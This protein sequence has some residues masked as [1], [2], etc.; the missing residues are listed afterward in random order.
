MNSIQTIFNRPWDILY[1]LPYSNN[2]QLT[3]RQQKRN[4]L[5]LIQGITKISINALKSFID[6]NIIDFD[7]QVGENLCQIRAYK[8]IHLADFWLNNLDNKNKLI[9]SI[10][11]LNEY[12]IN[13][14]LVIQEWEKSISEL[15]QYDKNLDGH[16]TIEEFLKRHNIYIKL[17]E[18][19]IYL[20]SCYFLTHY[21]ILD[22]NIPVAINFKE[23]SYAL[24]VSK[25]RAERLTHRYQLIVAKLGCDFIIKI[26][27]ELPLSA[28]Y[29]KL[30]PKLHQ[31][32]D[33]DR[34]VLP[35][36][37]VSEI[38]LQH[39]AKNSVN[40]LFLFNRVNLEQNEMIYFLLNESRYVNLAQLD[41][42][43]CLVISGTNYTTQ[44]TSKDYLQNLNLTELVLANT[45]THPQYS[46]SKLS[47]HRDNPFAS[48]LNSNDIDATFFSNRITNLKEVAD[49]FGCCKENPS[50]FLLNHI[51]ASTT[52]FEI[53][54]LI[55]HKK[56]IISGYNYL[57]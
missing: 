6:G 3:N 42:N 23:I 51:Y 35:C 14:D 20:I 44:P 4:E 49:K 17:F 21:A 25:H 16:E 57:V 2:F 24:T 1:L 18:D 13:I 41:S 15:K 8:N 26:A 54:K 27:S 37:I 30:L 7:A 48:L 38:I 11:I 43:Y 5:L 34:Y 40:I 45:A 56:L 52:S 29:S 31:L 32:S 47:A 12:K 50:E 46:G 28:L 9:K 39:C 10:R 53:N 22:D 33:V 55:S 36:Y 19:I